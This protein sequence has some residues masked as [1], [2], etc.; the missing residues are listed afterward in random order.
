MEV[1]GKKEKKA[2][3]KFWGCGENFDG[4]PGEERKVQFLKMNILNRRE[5]VRGKPILV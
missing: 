3:E 2:M 1:L 4:I 5:G